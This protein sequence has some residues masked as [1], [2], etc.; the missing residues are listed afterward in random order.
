MPAGQVIS[1]ENAGLYLMAFDLQEPWA[2]HR[3][4]EVFEDKYGDLFGCPE[5][6]ADHIV[7]CQVIM[8]AIEK[9]LPDL[10]N[11]LLARYVL[12]GYLLLYIVRQIINTDG[13]QDEII[14]HPE[15]FVRDKPTRERFRACIQKLVGDI[16]IDVND[17][18]EELGEN[19]DYRGKLRDRI[20]VKD[21]A[22]K[23]LV[24]YLK[25]VKRAR[26]TSL[27]EDWNE[28]EAA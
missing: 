25:Q 4:Y 22:K 6:T 28:V 7:L 2:T 10:K 21:L 19:F 15:N 27:S 12:T 18:V 14:N 11:T 23:V 16:I 17:E 5:V 3:K 8:E 9:G 24:D 13:L 1:N 26:I 20:W